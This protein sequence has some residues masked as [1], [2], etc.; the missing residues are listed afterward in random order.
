M[1]IRVFRIAVAAAMI[2]ICSLLVVPAGAN[3]AATKITIVSS[4]GSS[5]GSGWTNESGIISASGVV[6]IN[7]DDVTAALASGNLKVQADEVTISAPLVWGQ[8][9]RLTLE[10]AGALNINADIEAFGANAGL[11]LNSTPT[12]RLATWLGANIQL[13]GSNPSLK[14]DGTQFSVI[15]SAAQ[16]TTVS[17]SSTNIA[18]GRSLALTDTFADS[19]IPGAFASVFDGLGNEVSGL[20]IVRT[21]SATTNLGFFAELRG[22]TVRNFGVTDVYIQS[23]SSTTSN[24]LRIGAL[25]G[26]V[27]DAS[28]SSGWS[29][30]AYTTT[31][32]QVWSSG[33]VAAQDSGGAD[34]QG[35]FFGGGLVG[36]VNNGKLVILGSS[37][38]TNVSA[39]GTTSNAMAVGG[40]VGDAS[41]YP[42][43]GA[44]QLEIRQSY[45]T[46]SIVEGL[47]AAGTNYYGSGGLVGVLIGNS[48]SAISD[49]FSWSSIIATSPS[50]GGAVGYAGSGSI[51]SV[52]ATYNSSGS[53]GA[54]RLHYYWGVTNQTWSS[55]P[56]GFSAAVWG[57]NVPGM[58]YLL[59]QV[60]PQFPLYV[61]VV[62]PTDGSYATLSYQIVDASG[63]PANLA[64]LGLSSPS[65]VAQYSIDPAV[66]TGNYSVTY[67]SGLTLGGANAP[68]YYLAP[69]TTPTAVTIT[70]ALNRQTVTWAPTN[71][72]TA[73]TSSQ[74]TPN[75]VATSSGA[76]SITY[77]VQNAGGTGC[78][79]STTSP[80]IIS[81]NASGNCVI[82][83]TAAGTQTEA[84]GYKD[85]VFTFT[86]PQTQSVNWTPSNT[87]T[88][89]TTSSLT[90]DAPASTNGDGAISYSIHSAGG[91]GCSWNASSGV[92]TFTAAGT[93]IVRATAA[94]TANYAAATKDVTFTIGSTT[95][96]VTLELD[97]RVG[98]PV[99]NAPVLFS[100]TGLQPGSNW[101]L[102]V[103]STPQTLASGTTAGT[104]G[105]SGTAL[106]PS[107]L[108]A[109]WHTLTLSGTSLR[110]GLV[111]KTIWFE[112]A[113]N[114]TLLATQSTQPSSDDSTDANRNGA[115]SSTGASVS[116]YLVFAGMSALFGAA[117]IASRRRIKRR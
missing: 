38:S 22:A 41:N 48:S 88:I 82:R 23:A 111:S 77:A 19:I 37:S 55:L 105:L 67:V 1:T 52:Y 97:A 15:N 80:P 102:V 90:P 44:V 85:V 63:A 28:K 7:A 54:T 30:T 100:S 81:F 31:L 2:S 74:L 18:L 49:S 79:V 91:T 104:G 25:A 17:A 60:P 73:Y 71:T 76:G 103:R 61:K 83:A 47:R 4:G 92:L 12:Y 78:S 108:P 72:S 109:G 8:S 68:S 94:A 56:T 101:D 75:D 69:F 84:S 53:G 86:I 113:A 65:G 99:A 66:A 6:Q 34:Q 114:G 33:T 11:E 26:S 98:D 89:V 32:Q 59:N 96:A 117:L 46:G 20:T 106:I 43:T 35:V 29:A 14:I 9:T 36:S 45:A 70:A 87:E 5:E 51:T 95:T 116:M 40:L 57:I 10:S 13:P 112:V 21:A 64:S 110:G 115:L 50:S 42:S 24:N 107:G 16:L 3:A 62:A 39:A 27:G 93:C 58:P